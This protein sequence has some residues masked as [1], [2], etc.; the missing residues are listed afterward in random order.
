M[1][2]LIRFACGFHSQTD[3]LW[4]SDSKAQ[5]TP[6]N[7]S[8]TDQRICLLTALCM[9][10]TL[11]G[12]P[13]TNMNEWNVK[14]RIKNKSLKPRGPAISIPPSLYAPWSLLIHMRH[15]SYTVF[16]S[17]KTVAPI[18]HPNL[19]QPG[20]T[21][22]DELLSDHIKKL[23]PAETRICLLFA[24]GRDGLDQLKA[25]TQAASKTTNR[26]QTFKSS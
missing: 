6:R 2:L 4:V 15:S 13:W 22:I 18:S 20:E 8:T 11:N 17:S 19:N 25:M 16:G 23:I 14:M 1:P 10:S 26:C 9:E 5:T 24:V 3:Q 7:Q 12:K 21:E